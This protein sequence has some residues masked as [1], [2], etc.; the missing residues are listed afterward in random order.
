LSVVAT[1]A[2]AGTHTKTAGSGES[3]KQRIVALDALRGMALVT[4][5]LDHAAAFVSVN[6]QA[7]T[8]GG[9]PAILENWAHWVSGLITNLAAPTFWLLS[10]AS[11]ALLEASRRRSG[12]SEWEITRFLL[13]RAGIILALD[14]TLCEIAWNG[15]GPYTHVL[16]SIAL[17]LIVLSVARLLPLPVF[18][19]LSALLLLIYQLGVATIAAHFS[20]TLDFWQA[21]LLGYSTHTRPAVEYALA[22]WFSVMGLGYVLGRNLSSSWLRR[23]QVWVGFGAFLLSSW[24]VLRLLGGF[25]DLT[26]F[27]TQ[28]LWPHILIMG[29]TPPTLTYLAFNLGW[30]A[31]LLAIFQTR[32]EWLRRAPGQW[33]VWCGQV[34][35]F[36][37]VAHLIIYG[38]IGRL[39]LPLRLPI[40]GMA[41]AYGVW[42]AGLCLLLPS[43]KFYR[44]LR[45]RY[46]LLH[47]F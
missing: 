22:G 33:L 44:Q 1:H 24:F 40:P 37:F 9:Q 21:L 42:L 28:N 3:A 36:V 30:A 19:A 41:L 47:Y 46:A 25:G 31:L 7:E 20:Q 5:A 34:S 38:I 12:A 39:V 29:K 17:C 27:T 15:Q 8:Y 14:L 43:A 10:G 45:Q 2:S 11:I 26:P 13:I 35:L 16:L 6:L 32:S 23:A 18:A 4:M